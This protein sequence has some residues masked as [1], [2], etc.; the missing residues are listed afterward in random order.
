MCVRV[1]VSGFT[2][3][4][5]GGAGGHVQRPVAAEGAGALSEALFRFERPSALVL[6]PLV[7]FQ[8]YHQL[9]RLLSHVQP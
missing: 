6:Q 7:V 9:L 1:C 4:G 5:V 3:R 8:E 2:D